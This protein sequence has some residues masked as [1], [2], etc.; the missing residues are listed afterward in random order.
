M[1]TIARLLDQAIA[2]VQSRG[3]MMTLEDLLQALPSK[4][5]M[6][7]TIGLQPQQTMAH[8]MTTSLGLFGTGILVGAGLALLFAPK[9]GQE[10]RKDIAETMSAGMEQSGLSSLTSASPGSHA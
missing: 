7:G 9:P 4:K 10:L 5:D 3:N 1:S 8:E 2:T 6:A